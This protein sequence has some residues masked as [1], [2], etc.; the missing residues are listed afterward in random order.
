MAEFKVNRYTGGNRQPSLA[1]STR[2]P[3]LVSAPQLP[4]P[5][6]VERKRKP[7]KGTLDKAEKLRGEVRKSATTFGLQKSKIIDAVNAGDVDGSILAFQRTA[8]SAVVSIIPIAERE[9]RKF[10]RES[11]AY[12]LNALI[13]SAREL[14]QDLAATND[15]AMLADRLLQESLVPFIKALLQHIV[16]QNVILKGFLSDKLKPG[17]S[18]TVVANID[19]ELR[20]TAAYMQSMY[21]LCTEQIKKAVQGN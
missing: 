11:Q 18:P 8:Y 13:Q 15:R 3:K 19:S 4:A 9:Y 1:P 12:A 14:S 2:R 5:V 6:K 17:V 21:E 7:A 10:K 20:N 16:Q